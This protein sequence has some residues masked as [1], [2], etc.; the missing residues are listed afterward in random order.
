[1]RENLPPNAVVASW[2]DYGYWI[3]IWGNKTSLADN[4]TINSTQI[5][6]IGYMFMSNETE[7]IKVLEKFNQL[8]RARGFN[9]NVSHVL[10]FTTFDINGNDARL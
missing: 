8:A 4:G 5:G 6:K 7:A 10:V 1:M 9:H 2:W 3:T